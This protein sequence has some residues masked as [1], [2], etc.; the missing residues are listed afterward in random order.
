MEFAKANTAIDYNMIANEMGFSV[1]QQL[2]FYEGKVSEPELNYTAKYEPTTGEI[3][4]NTQA[5]T[6]KGKKILSGQ[7]LTPEAILRHELGHYR[8]FYDS[9]NSLG[10]DALEN[11]LVEYY[12]S[13]Y[14]KYGGSLDLSTNSKPNPNVLNIL[15][16]KGIDKDMATNMLFGDRSSFNRDFYQTAIESNTRPVIESNHANEYLSALLDKINGLSEEEM[17]QLAQ[18]HTIQLPCKNI[19]R[20]M[21]QNYLNYLI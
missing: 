7:K 1:K 9:A 21:M 17:R 15:E 5:L 3:K 10:I 4:Y 12:K 18:K 11:T 14:E 13:A 6:P 2:T 8:Q 19:L 20:P 16:R